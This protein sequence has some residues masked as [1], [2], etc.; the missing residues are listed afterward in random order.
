MESSEFYKYANNE[1]CIFCGEHSGENRR[2]C[3]DCWD[4]DEVEKAFRDLNRENIALTEECCGCGEFFY[5]RETHC[6]TCREKSKWRSFRKCGPSF[7]GDFIVFLI[8]GSQAVLTWKPNTKKWCFL[9]SEKPYH[10]KVTHWAFLLDGP[11]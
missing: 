10:T 9:K 8:D 2:V 5:S 3:L 1:K 11:K 7:E 6:R 4:Q